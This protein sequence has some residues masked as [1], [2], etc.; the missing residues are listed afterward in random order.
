MLYTICIVLN[1]MCEQVISQLQDN[2]MLRKFGSNLLEKI[3]RGGSH[4]QNPYKKY[5]QRFPNKRRKMM[6]TSNQIEVYAKLWLKNM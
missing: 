5:V 6:S 3:D 4:F 2:Y 1:I